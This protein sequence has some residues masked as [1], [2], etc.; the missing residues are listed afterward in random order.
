MAMSF[1]RSAIVLGLLAAVGPLAIDM[2]LPALPTIATD[3]NTSI[4]AV[5]ATLT[6]FFIAFGV[7][8]IAY[9]PISDM[10][11]RKP[12]L[13]FGLGLFIVG[14]VGCL[15]SP[16]VEWLIFFRFIQ[17]LGA[18]SSWW[19]PVRSSATCIPASRRHA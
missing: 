11:G 9:G 5:Q 6:V 18:A 4:A 19:C 17:G 7:S 12:P 15:L 1:A 2:Y 8:Q 13:Y 3:L 10:V 14:A 16:S